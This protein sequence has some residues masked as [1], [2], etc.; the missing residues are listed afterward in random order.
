[1]G[2]LITLN[3]IHDK[4]IASLNWSGWQ[5]ANA[6]LA[7]FLNAEFHPGTLHP[8]EGDPIRGTVRKLQAF[9]GS[10]AAISYADLPPGDGSRVH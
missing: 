7:A 8:G 5:S 3:L 4:L 10:R 1:M 2:A 6:A 9:Y